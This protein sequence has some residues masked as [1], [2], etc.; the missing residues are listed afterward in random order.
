VPKA[1]V[2]EQ[3]NRNDERVT[4]DGK[5]PVVFGFVRNIPG[6]KADCVAEKFSDARDDTD[7]HG[8]RAEQFKIRAVN[9]ACTFVNNVAKKTYESEQ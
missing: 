4:E 3:G 5:K 6:N 1:C 2:S 8:I 7:H 9:A